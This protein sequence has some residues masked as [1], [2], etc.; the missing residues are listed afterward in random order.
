IDLVMDRT[1]A[2]TLLLLSLF[3]AFGKYVKIEEPM[4]WQQAQEHC[5]T[6]YTDLAPISSYRDIARLQILAEDGNIFY[7]IGMRRGSEDIGKWSWSGGG[8]VSRHFWAEGQPDNGTQ[9]TYAAFYQ[10]QVHDV[11][12]RDIAVFCYRVVVVREKMTWE[13]ALDHCEEHHSNLAS[14]ASETEMMLIQREL[15]KITTTEHVWIGLRF[16]PG[17]WQ[18][19]DQQQLDYEAWSQDK[20]PTCP[21][22]SVQCGALKAVGRPESDKRFK[23]EEVKRKKKNK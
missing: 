12:E 10:G 18:W 17:G 20:K 11:T 9:E 13:D 1:F 23:C 22:L 15:G 7:W 5:R 6:Q 19:V 2:G 21:H 4:G 16:I 8:E 3:A 14:V